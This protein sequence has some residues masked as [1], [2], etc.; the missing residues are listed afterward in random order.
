[1]GVG[2]GEGEGGGLE[3]GKGVFGE[4]VVGGCVGV[5]K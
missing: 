2:C 1:M 4:G 3:L 5:S